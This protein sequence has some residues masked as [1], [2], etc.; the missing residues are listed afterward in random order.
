MKKFKQMGKDSE[1]MVMAVGFSL[2]LLALFQYSSTKSKQYAMQ[3]YSSNSQLRTHPTNIDA[4]TN[5]LSNNVPSQ[6]LGNNSS[7]A[8]NEIPKAKGGSP[9]DLLPKDANSQWASLNPTGNG[10]LENVNLL[11]AGSLTG[12]NTVS[13]TL[14]NANLQIRAEPSNPKMNVG[15]WQNSTIER[16]SKYQFGL[17]VD[18]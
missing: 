12:I 11:P 3:G 15:P 5:I 6:A 16:D 17:K 4:N 13:N 8:S 10:N 14:K 2:L 7:F 9:V 1:K 18:C